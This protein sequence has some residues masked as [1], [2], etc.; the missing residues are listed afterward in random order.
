MCKAKHDPRVGA[1]SEKR[2]SLSAHRHRGVADCLFPSR[3]GT[4]D[5]CMRPLC[6]HNC[7]NV[8][9][10]SYPRSRYGNLFVRWPS[11]LLKKLNQEA[12]CTAKRLL[13]CLV[14][15]VF[16]G[17][18]TTSE[19][20]CKLREPGKYNLVRSFAEFTSFPWTS[21]ILC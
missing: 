8:G 11:F 12:N 7:R 6:G 1:K 13:F 14:D 9:I 10:Q 5:A 17:Q 18:E 15:A 4:G 20:G 3:I 16:V 19:R 2:I 21:S